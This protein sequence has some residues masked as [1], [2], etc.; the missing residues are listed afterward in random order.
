MNTLGNISMKSIHQLFMIH[1]YFND[2]NLIN[3]NV[4][5]K[6][7]QKIRKIMMISLHRAHIEMMINV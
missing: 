5:E 1:F 2:Y 4:F 6:T 3:D 7:L